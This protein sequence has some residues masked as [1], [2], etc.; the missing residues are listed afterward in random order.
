MHMRYAAPIVIV[1]QSCQLC[2]H[3]THLTFAQVHSMRNV[4]LIVD[5]CQCFNKTK[6]IQKKKKK[7]EKM[8]MLTSGGV[9]NC[10]A[11]LNLH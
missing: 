3:D 5:N 1:K 2:Q 11:K 9:L 6:Q 8:K 7:N 10:S 4:N